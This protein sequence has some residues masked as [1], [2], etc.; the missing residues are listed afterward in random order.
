MR[1][2]IMTCLILSGVLM[3]PMRA[4]ASSADPLS[5]EDYKV[6]AS[7]GIA[8]D[9]KMV[10]GLT[11]K[12]RVKARQLIVEK[13][14]AELKSFLV[15]RYLAHKVVTSPD[16]PDLDKT[17]IALVQQNFDLMYCEDIREEMICYNAMLYYESKYGIEPARGLKL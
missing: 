1:Q 2:Q 17:E 11:E 6:I 14:V 12:E 3:Q 7:L 5:P 10:T 8:L 16:I 4:A 15:T 9:S 13:P